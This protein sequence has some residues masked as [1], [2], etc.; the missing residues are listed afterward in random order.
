MDGTPSMDVHGQLHQLQ[1]CKLLQHK[2][3]VVWTEGL[4]VKLE[5]LQ[6]TFHELSLWDAAAPSEPTYKWQLIEVD[7][8]S[9]QPESMTTTIQTTTTIPV[10][11]PSL[12]NTIEPPSDITAAINLQLKG[13]LEQL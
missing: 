9:M 7:L 8:S 5:A 4:N 11:P 13:A 1:I 2:D 10:L 3:M 12:A 6:F